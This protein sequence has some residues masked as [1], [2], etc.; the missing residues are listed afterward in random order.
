MTKS[1]C[2]ALMNDHL[3]SALKTYQASSAIT[4]EVLAERMGISPRACSALE[5]GKSGFSALS[6]VRLLALLPAPD[7]LALL[8][9]LCASIADDVPE[10]A[11]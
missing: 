8:A 4:Q 5:N 2:K 10:K 7:R 1:E 11:S 3:R 6:A 9:K